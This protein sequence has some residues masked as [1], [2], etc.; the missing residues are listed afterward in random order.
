MY[1]YRYVNMHSQ[2]G[3][4]A[5]TLLLDDLEG[6]MPSVRIDKEFGMPISQI[7]DETLYQAASLEIQTAQ[8]AY[9][10]YLA[11]QAQTT[12]DAAVQAQ[13]DADALAALI[14]SENGS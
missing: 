13:S 14:A 1:R 7:D 5:C 2:F 12:A 10:A 11:E 3:R 8:G 9:D 4:T 6:D